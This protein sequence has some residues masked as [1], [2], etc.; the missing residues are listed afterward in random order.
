MVHS[1]SQSGRCIRKGGHARHG[2]AGRHHHG[3]GGRVFGRLRRIASIGI[4]H[5]RQ[6]A[7]PN[8]VQIDIVL[9]AT[10]PNG[11]RNFDSVKGFRT[12]KAPKGPL[13]VVARRQGPGGSNFLLI[14]GRSVQSNVGG[15]FD[16]IQKSHRV[17]GF[18]EGQNDG[19]PNIVVAFEISHVRALLTLLSHNGHGGTSG[20][21]SASEF[22]EGGKLVAGDSLHVRQTG[23]FQ[24]NQVGISHQRALAGERLIGAVTIVQVLIIDTACRRYRTDGGC[25][26]CGTGRWFGCGTCRWCIRDHTGGGDWTCG[27]TG[28]WSLRNRAGG[29]CH[30]HRAGGGRRCNGTGGGCRRGGCQSGRIVVIVATTV[31]GTGRSIHRDANF[32]HAVAIEIVGNLLHFHLNI[33]AFQA[34]FP[35]SILAQFGVQFRVR[36][37]RTVGT[38][39][40]NG[41]LILRLHRVRI[42]LQGQ[43]E[44]EV[45]VAIGIQFNLDDLGTIRIVPILRHHALQMV[46]GTAPIVDR[47][48]LRRIGMGRPQPS[49]DPIHGPVETHFAIV[50]VRISHD[51][52][53]VGVIAIFVGMSQ[54]QIVP[55]LVHLRRIVGAPHVVVDGIPTPHHGVGQTAGGPGGQAH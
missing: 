36:V 38:G 19:P 29:G 42:E 39:F 22:H 10:P 11:R 49:Q 55:H 2:A 33:L 53:I 8:V 15:I 47:K 50:V 18:V 21:R 27:R 13:V 14:V 20:S 12:L 17:D 45:V 48:G 23:V 1:L 44:H 3:G 40:D 4:R 16:A 46:P 5:A 37:A 31:V 51:A 28:R 9:G 24:V 52:G 30:S 34:G 26:C 6:R 25:H 35:T 7:K 54:I 32:G 43:I 41:D